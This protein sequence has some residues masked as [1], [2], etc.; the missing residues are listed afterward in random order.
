MNDMPPK[1]APLRKLRFW[2]EGF[3]ETL[4]WKPGFDDPDVPRA[5]G[6][7]A[8]LIEASVKYDP[9]GDTVA[10]IFLAPAPP[11]IGSDA[12]LLMQC[13]DAGTLI[14]LLLRHGWTPAQL[15]EKTKSGSLGRTVALYLARC[16]RV[17]WVQP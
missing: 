10:E 5:G 12:G 7:V 15:V 17:E 14:S 11:H 6:T 16:P 1:D 8:H 2:R 3:T 4:R 13:A 9:P